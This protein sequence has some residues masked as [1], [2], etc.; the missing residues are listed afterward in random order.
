MM[1]IFYHYIWEKF[2]FLRHIIVFEVWNTKIRSLKLFNPGRGFISI[3][4]LLPSAPSWNW[5]S[6]CLHVGC[7]TLEY[8]FLQFQL[9]FKLQ[10]CST[11]SLCNSSFIQWCRTTHLPAL[12]LLT[13][14][15][16]SKTSM[17]HW[18]SYILNTDAVELGGGGS[19]PFLKGPCGGRFLFQ[20][21]KQTQSDQS[22]VWRL[23][24][25]D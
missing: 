12:W 11:F 25:V 21:I 18:K 2:R 13:N 23:R 15:A 19:E 20:P 10:M 7:S 3:C 5:F 14:I 9:Y 16:W 1:F 6:A 24:F 8:W 17:M 22:A 4:N